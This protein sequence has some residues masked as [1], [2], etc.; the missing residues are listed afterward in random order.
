MSVLEDEKLLALFARQRQIDQAILA[1]AAELGL[2][3]EVAIIIHFPNDG[4][5]CVLTSLHDARLLAVLRRTVRAV[6]RGQHRI[7]ELM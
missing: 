7:A 1:R 3:L 2:P 5:Q 4:E 6:E